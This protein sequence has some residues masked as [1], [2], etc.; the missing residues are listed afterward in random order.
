MIKLHHEFLNL[1]SFKKPIKLI[2]KDFNEFLDLMMENDLL[3]L[4]MYYKNLKKITISFDSLLN[5]HES[6]SVKLTIIHWNKFKKQK[7]DISNNK[8]PIKIAFIHQLLNEINWYWNANK[9]VYFVDNKIKNTNKSIK[10]EE[11]FWESTSNNM[12]YTDHFYLL[13]YANVITSNYDKAL[14]YFKKV[15]DN[16]QGIRRYQ[17]SYN[18]IQLYG[19]LGQIKNMVLSIFSLE[20]ELAI[21]D[22][23]DMGD[24]KEMQNWVINN[25]NFHREHIKKS[26]ISI[27]DDNL[28]F[29]SNTTFIIKFGYEFLPSDYK[30]IHLVL[31]IILSTSCRVLKY[32]EG[33][34]DF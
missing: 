22:I 3:R 21:L 25:S 33:I 8:Y 27:F 9:L 10:L 26:K 17:A 30:F 13:A 5:I 6:R 24:L 2:G 19:Y 1:D 16:G 15:S 12:N 34:N 23:N 20:R 11:Y 32:F 7:F 29:N 14:E 4:Q 28:N 31:Q 18:L